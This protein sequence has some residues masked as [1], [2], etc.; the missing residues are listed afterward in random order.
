MVWVSLES[1]GRRYGTGAIRWITARNG[2]TVNDLVVGAKMTYMDDRRV[3]PEAEAARTKAE[4]ALES[5]RFCS[6][7]VRLPALS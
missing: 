7:I 4:V 3:E 5:R 1:F 2:T 6:P